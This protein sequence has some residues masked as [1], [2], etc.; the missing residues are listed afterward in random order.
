MDVYV[1]ISACLCVYI[2]YYCLDI[3]FFVFVYM[4]ARMSKKNF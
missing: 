4:N 3:R 1:C 2:V